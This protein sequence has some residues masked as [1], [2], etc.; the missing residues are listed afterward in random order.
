M[1]RVDRTSA[2]GPE[3]WV[4]LPLMK[5]PRCADPRKD[6]A[7]IVFCV[8]ALLDAL[9]VDQNIERAKRLSR[10]IDQRRQA[11]WPSR[12]RIDRV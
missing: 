5:Q 1:N 3:T 9:A 12:C 10:P 8:F 6:G 7:E 2:P 4:E 11:P